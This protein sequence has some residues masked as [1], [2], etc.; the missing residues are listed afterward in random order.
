MAAMEAAIR[1]T[2]APRAAM[3]TSAHAPHCT[4]VATRAHVR[5]YEPSVQWGAWAEV[6]M[7]ARGA[8]AERMAAMEA[9]SGFGRIGLAQGLGALQTAVLPQAAPLL[10]VVPVQWERALGKDQV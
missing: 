10:G 7:A 2:A 4:L 3:P 8:A 1:S 5:R 9:A 6:G